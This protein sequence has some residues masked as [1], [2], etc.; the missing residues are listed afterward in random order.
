MSS[1][2]QRH[3]AALAQTLREVREHLEE[4]EASPWDAI[5]MMETKLAYFCAGENAMF[6]RGRFIKAARL[7]NE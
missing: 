6:D 5:N 1:L 2:S 7:K 3:F 4:N